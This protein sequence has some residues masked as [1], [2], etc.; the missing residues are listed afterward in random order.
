MLN[1][2]VIPIPVFILANNGDVTSY[3]NQL[4]VLLQ[5]LLLLALILIRELIPKYSVVIGD[6]L[7]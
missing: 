6:K 7:E 1:T 3:Y 2:I 5:E 4:Q